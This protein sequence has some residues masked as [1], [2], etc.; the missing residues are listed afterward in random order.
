[1]IDFACETIRV[2]D[3]IRCSF[4]LSGTEYEVLESLLDSDDED[5]KE[6]AEGLDLERST[7]HKALQTLVD[8]NLVE[9]RQLNL[10][11]GGY[12]YVYSAEPKEEI[13]ERVLNLMDE[14]TSSAK[15][16]VQDW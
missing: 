11:S 16:S 6:I 7:A 2:E 3:L 15:E 9:K 1:M 12:K 13:K 8:R 10:S 5:V 4:R 14:W